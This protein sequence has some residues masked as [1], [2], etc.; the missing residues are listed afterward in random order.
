MCARAG[1][2]GAREGWPQH[3]RRREGDGEERPRADLG[4]GGL[5]G[6]ARAGGGVREGRFDSMRWERVCVSASSRRWSRDGVGL[7]ARA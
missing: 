4:D 1:A 7:T 5:D 2:W 3:V 6:G